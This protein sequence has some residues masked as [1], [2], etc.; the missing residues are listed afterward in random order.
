MLVNPR[1]KTP[2]GG[3]VAGSLNA[4]IPGSIGPVVFWSAL[5]KK[6]EHYAAF[7]HL[8]CAQLMLAKVFRGK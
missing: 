3:S 5:E 1:Q 7:L 4:P 8:A 6:V 2:F